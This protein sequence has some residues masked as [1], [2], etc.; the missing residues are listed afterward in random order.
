MKSTTLVT[1][2]S[3]ESLNLFLLQKLPLLALTIL[4][5]KKHCKLI[6]HL[7]LRTLLRPVKLSKLCLTKI[8]LLKKRGTKQHVTFFKYLLLRQRTN[9][10]KKS[11]GLLEKNTW[12]QTE[13]ITIMANIDMDMV[14]LNFS[15]MMKDMDMDMKAIKIMS[16][17]RELRLWQR[18]K[19]IQSTSMKASSNL[20]MLSWLMIL[21][22]HKQ[23]I[24]PNILR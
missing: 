11:R 10:G 17:K 7:Q 9:F 2:L 14:M 12:M 6:P 13:D 23:S 20:H 16:C 8:K 5:Y 24:S 1:M 15:I 3:G 21:Q 18:L 22:Q 19:L 4:I